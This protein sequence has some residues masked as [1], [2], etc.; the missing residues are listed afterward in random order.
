MKKIFKNLLVVFAFA[1]VLVGVTG[2]GDKGL[3]GSWK[4][5]SFIYTFNEDKTG[6]Y[7]F[8]DAKMKFKYEDDGKK[9]KIT[10]VGNTTGST[11]EYKIDGKKLIIKDSFGK[12]VEYTKK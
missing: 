5:G 7:S 3:V 11:Y 10:Y 8:G 4:H 2:C 12:D 6:D 1:F 9:V